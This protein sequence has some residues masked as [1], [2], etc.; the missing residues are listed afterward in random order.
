MNP[1]LS[2]ASARPD[3]TVSVSGDMHFL[4]VR[5]S[6]G[7]ALSAVLFFLLVLLIVY[8]PGF[9]GTWIY[10]DAAN[11]LENKN[12]H[13]AQINAAS[14]K[15]TFFLE[16]E[17]PEKAH[18]IRRPLAYLSFALNWYWG[19]NQVVGYHVVNFLIH[20][21]ATTFLYLFIKKSLMVMP[22]SDNRHRD[23]AHLTAFLSAL[24]WAIHPVQV[25]A[26]TY[27]VQRMASMAGMF[28]IMGM[29]GYLQ[30]RTAVTRAGM[31]AGFLAC[32]FCALCAFAS[33]ENSAMLPVSLF[34]YEILILRGMPRAGFKEMLKWGLPALAMVIVVGML[35]ISP[36]S[37]L[38]GYVNRPYTP[39]E[40]VMTQ[41]RVM[42]IYL[43]LLFY[44]LLSEMTLVHDIDVSTS[45]WS[46]WTTPLSIILVFLVLFFSLFRL[47][48]RHPFAGFAILF[49]FLNHA[50]EASFIGL[51][52]IFEHR[53]YIPSMMLFS[54]PV[55]LFVHSLRYF[56]YHRKLQLLLLLGG[57]VVLA[58][59]GHSTHA[60]NGLFRHGLVY[61][62]DNARKSPGLGVVQNNYAVELM[63]RG[64]YGEA[65]ER[66]Q[67]AKA[68]GRYFNLSQEGVTDYNLGLYYQSI[69]QDHARAL[70]CFQRAVTT[71]LNS[72]KMWG[73]L[74]RSYLINNHVEA[75]VATVRKALEKWPQDAVF[76][77]MM[78]EL[79]L[80]MGKTGTAF[81]YAREARRQHPGFEEPLAIFGELY[82]LRGNL[83]KARFFWQAY[84]K[85]RPDSMI[86]A[87]V[88]VG[89]YDQT[90]D[91]R[92]LDR[93]VAGLMAKK[94]GKRLDLWLQDRLDEEKHLDRVIAIPAPDHLFSVI[95]FSLKRAAQNAEHGR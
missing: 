54:L 12:V 87:L 23:R 16:S 2:A 43:K 42:W 62:K 10:D 68:S 19:K 65:F 67:R 45:F 15:K 58:S 61:W 93:V 39:L 18:K 72:K 77:T 13:M 4:Q 35:Y 50:I 29:Y 92:R 6:T 31:A 53:N 52:L 14:L 36:G 88:L 83:P 75:A 1:Y 60:Y 64:E 32:G 26:V 79:Q 51:E 76:L 73:A 78:S 20:L 38:D 22:G 40:R 41:S 91:D 49:F 55:M 63:K 28:T 57:S 94:G 25:T 71:T 8:A 84:H 86:A 69:E 33:K 89:L 85:K 70:A 46:P 59:M 47:A 27:I 56:A 37:L 17:N 21:T 44:P 74:C 48:D 82:R 9:S 5:R 24:I 80:M 11:I 95:S 34:F 81:A 3:N 66:L 7:Q 90:G 30:A